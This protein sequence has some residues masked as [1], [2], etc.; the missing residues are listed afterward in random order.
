[1]E[2]IYDAYFVGIITFCL[3]QMTACFSGSI[4]AF[5]EQVISWLR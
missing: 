2:V 3:A 4:F 5:I 1:V